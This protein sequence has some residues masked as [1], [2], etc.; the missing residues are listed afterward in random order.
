MIISSVQKAVFRV[1]YIPQAY[2]ANDENLLDFFNIKKL[3]FE[4]NV[5]IELLKT[6]Y[7]DPELAEGDFVE[8]KITD[9]ETN[10]EIKIKAPED[11]ILNCIDSKKVQI[12]NLN[13]VDGISIFPNYECGSLELIID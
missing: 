2:T 5:L 1:T 4:K 6:D 11:E 3:S 7:K 12:E 9:P 13:C 8:L 10:K